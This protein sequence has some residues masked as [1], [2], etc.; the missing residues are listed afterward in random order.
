MSLISRLSK[1]FVLFL[2]LAITASCA[3]TPTALDQEIITASIKEDLKALEIDA[4]LT[5]IDLYTA[6]AIAIKNNRDLRISV[7][8]SAL[9]QR[10]NDL[11]RFDMLP[12]MALN[13]GYS[14]FAELQPSTSVAVD[15][16]SQSAPALDGTESYTIS[17][18]NGLET[19]NVEF[20]WNALDFGL[21]YIRAGQQADRFLIAEELERKATQNITRDI[22]RAYWKAKA[23]ENLL[24]K[25]NPLLDRVDAALADSKYIEELLISS[26]MDSL[27]YQ[28]ELLDVQRTLQTQ[29]R[30][31]INSKNELATL[32]GLLPN[33][34]YTL[35]KE[36]EYLTNVDMDIETMEEIALI[37]RPELME[38]R[39]QKRIT[40]KDARAA[41]V[42][43]IPSLK[44]NATYGY[45]DNDYL[46]N[47]D[48]TEYGASIGANLFDIFS[49][50]AVKKASEANQD[51]I[52]ER[53]L[54]I[55]MT[56]LSQ[57]HLANINYDLAIEEY[58][59]AQ[60]YL[61]VAIRISNQVQN[62]QKVSRFG[63]LEVIREEASLL[64]A[65]LRRDLAFSEMQHSIG[66]IYA[67]MG[68]DMLPENY[69]NL[70]IEN[71]AENVGINFNE[72]SEKY[73]AKVQNPI[74][75]QDPTLIIINDPI[76]TTLTSNKFIISKET[77]DIT[78]P[79]KI[80]YSASQA[81][82]S[83]LPRWLAF[84][85]SDL[86]IVGNPPADISGI[87]LKL[88]IA[89]AVISAEDNFTLNFIDEE[90]LLTEEANQARKD[91][92]ALQ[93]ESATMEEEL[94]EIVNEE[95]LNE[96]DVTEQTAQTS[97]IE[98]Q[99]TTEISSNEID[100]TMPYVDLNT[101]SI[102]NG[103]VVDTNSILNELLDSIDETMNEAD[104]LLNSSI[105]IGDPVIDQEE[106]I[107]IEETNEVEAS[108]EVEETNEVEVAVESE[109]TTLQTSNLTP[110]KK[111]IVS[112]AD[113][114]ALVEESEKALNELIEI[115]EAKKEKL[116]VNEAQEALN[117]LMNI[118]LNKKKEIENNLV[119]EAELALQELALIISEEDNNSTGGAFTAQADELEAVEEEPQTENEELIYIKL[120]SYKR[121]NP[122]IGM[123]NYVYKIMGID[124]RFLKY[125]INV[126]K[127]EDNNFS[128]IIGPMPKSEAHSMIDILDIHLSFETKSTMKAELICNEQVI[129]MCEL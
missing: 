2:L 53:H 66:Q 81:D 38:S 42:G 97:V 70:S 51:L 32:M 127:S 95:E 109:E 128:V 104:A 49:I 90:T 107:E 103:L 13:A 25:L 73:Y 108:I 114:N 119:N 39:Y 93:L 11:T 125:E 4:P 76:N 88:T 31:L 124:A 67:S 65:E 26:P 105:E 12:D 16:D 10:Q 19:R 17:R 118:S 30:A 85:S 23:S 22:I 110:Q 7:M 99:P 87:N 36:D 92:A 48:T 50:G 120:G 72:W 21:S 123:M 129:L 41:I 35:A 9:A 33:Q 54:A 68:K 3:R 71:V 47:Q 113:E 5:N 44:F 20:T 69:E 62:A 15:N 27:L 121:G 46:L 112:S 94:L 37:S 86:S 40:S 82:G 57:V 63:E 116:L 102:S 84:L 117:D 91:L 98:E 43:L 28:K 78:G 75:K 77:F 18:D 89:N 64:V 61:D 100:F 34:R 29:Q 52:K 59:T 58:D 24:K 122:A 79:G 56:V 55:A 115:T 6:I 126:D 74:D 8:E 111:P 45:S 83:E 60:R 14:E 101:Y 80:R 106:V 96:T 1:T